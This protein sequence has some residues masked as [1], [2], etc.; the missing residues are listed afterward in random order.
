[1]SKPIIKLTI[2]V[3]ILSTQCISKKQEACFVEIKYD[4]NILKNQYLDFIS[5]LNYPFSR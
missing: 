3:L 4:E 1:M 5:S 2:L